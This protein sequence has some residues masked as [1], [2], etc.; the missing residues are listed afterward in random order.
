M[1]KEEPNIREMDILELE[2]YIQ[3]RHLRK[4][5]ENNG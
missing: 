5:E 2:G 3:T 1:K 4:Q